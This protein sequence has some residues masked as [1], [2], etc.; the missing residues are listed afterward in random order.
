MKSIITVILLSLMLNS[1]VLSLTSHRAY[2]RVK[3]IAV[4]QDS[5]IADAQ[6]LM[7]LEMEDVCNG[8][9]IEQSSMTRV[10]YKSRPPETL[11][12]NYAAWE[13]KAGDKL[14]FYA[15]RTY[16][17]RFKEGVQGQADFTDPKAQGRINFSQPEQVTLLMQGGTMPPVK[18]IQQLLAAANKG[19]KMFSKHVFDGSF[20]GKPVNINAFIGRQQSS[21]KNI[22]IKGVD[23]K[24]WP[25][26]LAIFSGEGENSLPSFEIQQEMNDQGILLNYTVDFGEYALKGTLERVE[27]LPKI[28]CS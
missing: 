1:P 17:N 20:Y 7:T 22:P 4:K 24:F 19:Q 16:N 27:F 15:M 13:S 8:W 10:S 6:G 3:L 5:D 23:P 9:T 25:I 11:N 28:S 18:H 21:D 14:K 26:N 2:Y 12:A